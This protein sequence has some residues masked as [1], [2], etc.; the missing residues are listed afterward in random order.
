MHKVQMHVAFAFQ[1]DVSGMD[2]NA[3]LSLGTL[4]KM[5]PDGA[6]LI[7]KDLKHP[8]VKIGGRGNR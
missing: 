5:L 2:L 8:V 7:A 6:K 1:V 4:A 3:K